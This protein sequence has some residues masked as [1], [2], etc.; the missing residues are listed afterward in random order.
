MKRSGKLLSI[1]LVALTASISAA[2][3]F[4][5]LHS[6]SDAGTVDNPIKTTP[7]SIDADYHDVKSQAQLKG[8]EDRKN[9]VYLEGNAFLLKMDIPEMEDEATAYVDDRLARSKRGDGQASYEIFTRISSC[10]RA[11]DPGDSEEYKAYASVG[12]GGQF[13]E[14]VER[15]IELCK[16]LNSRDDI[17]SENWL[18]LAAE[19][20]SIEARLMY[21]RNPREVVGDLSNA[22]KNP[23]EIINYR[24]NAVRY[25]QESVSTGS[26]DSME[27]LANIYDR[28]ILAEKSPEQSLAY[29]L[30]YDRLNRNELSTT[31][32]NRISVDLS[33]DQSQ[34][35]REMAGKILNSCCK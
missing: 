15:E 22:L 32:I 28:G 13:S 6:T 7:A 12:L 33:P 16:G 26:V 19:Q 23:E 9:R 24:T 8:Y 31:A 21:A 17:T 3:Y 29:W 25:L 20:G 5:I 14:R 11:L 1:S 2:I 18:A 27:A 4:F 35:A 30:A 34:A 10:R